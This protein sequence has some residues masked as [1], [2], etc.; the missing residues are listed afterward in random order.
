MNFIKISWNSRIAY[1]ILK[2]N[3]NP[4]NFSDSHQTLIESYSNNEEHKVIS[5]RWL[6]INIKESFDSPLEAYP[7]DLHQNLV[8][9]WYH[10]NFSDSR[11]TLIELYSINDDHKVISV[12]WCIINMQ[13]S[14]DS[15]DEI[16]SSDFYQK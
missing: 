2:C 10:Q 9:E 13:V 14:F 8:V 6:I 3:D 5:V 16:D 11:Q 1:Q 12:W 15:L 4:Q 7:M